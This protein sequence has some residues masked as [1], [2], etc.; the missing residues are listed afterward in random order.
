MLAPRVFQQRVKNI[1]RHSVD[2]HLLGHS[3]TAFTKIQEWYRTGTNI[4][5]H[6][7]KESA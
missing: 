7:R 5:Y 6:A 4:F 1:E 3:G 2:G